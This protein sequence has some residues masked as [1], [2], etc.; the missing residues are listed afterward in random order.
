MHTYV[1]KVHAKIN[2]L[3]PCHLLFTILLQYWIPRA[4]KRNPC[5]QTVY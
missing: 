4:F 5:V 2:L 1:R 3:A